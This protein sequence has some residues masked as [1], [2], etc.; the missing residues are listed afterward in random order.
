MPSTLSASQERP[1]SN[2]Q[3]IEE[4][5]SSNPLSS[6]TIG[7]KSP[8]KKPGLDATLAPNH[9]HQPLHIQERVSALPHPQLSV[10]GPRE[11][12]GGFLG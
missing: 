12:V 1:S 11:Q 7:D 2:F 5:L 8:R 6:L 3:V 10:L 4:E 9:W